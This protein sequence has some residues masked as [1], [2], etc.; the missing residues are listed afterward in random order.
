MKNCRPI[1]Q[2]V[3]INF[4]VVGLGAATSNSMES[5]IY[6]ALDAFILKAAALVFRCFSAFLGFTLLGGTNAH[7]RSCTP[8]VS[9]VELQDGT[10][11][12]GQNKNLHSGRTEAAAAGTR[13]QLA[14]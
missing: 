13:G 5:N 2:D 4:S 14:G 12:P 3:S 6:L 7:T 9:S 11:E 10:A 1:S 8:Q